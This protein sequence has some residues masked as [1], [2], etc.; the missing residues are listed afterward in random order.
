MRFFEF[1]FGIFQAIMAG[2]FWVNFT[3][4]GD[5][6][7]DVLWGLV[8][9]TF[10]NNEQSNAM[11]LLGAIIMPHNLYLQSAMIVERKIEIL[12]KSQS[13]HFYI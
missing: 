1:T 3:K 8:P 7:M 2:T 10:G 4:V 9:R 5:T 12:T 6:P 11:S 13:K